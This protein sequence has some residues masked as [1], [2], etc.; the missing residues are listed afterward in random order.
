[1]KNTTL[2]VFKHSELVSEQI[3]GNGFANEKSI[4]VASTIN[5]E[6]TLFF[7]ISIESLVSNTMFF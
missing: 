2:C 6:G 1:M 4:S 7:K 5:S 3:S